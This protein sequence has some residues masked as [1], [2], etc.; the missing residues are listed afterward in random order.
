MESFVVE[1]SLHLL[2]ED[3][4]PVFPLMGE[5]QGSPN[6]KDLMNSIRDGYP[7]GLIVAT[8]GKLKGFES[9]IDERVRRGAAEANSL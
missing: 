4:E 1:L 6:L 3:K 9:I 7:K 5:E 8:E 2:D